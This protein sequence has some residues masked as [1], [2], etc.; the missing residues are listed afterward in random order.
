[1][2]DQRGVRINVY[3]AAATEFAN[4][5]AANAW[6]GHACCEE[7]KR[8]A[9][10]QQT[11]K[12]RELAARLMSSSSNDRSASEGGHRQTQAAVRPPMETRPHFGAVLPELDDV[13]A[14]SRRRDCQSAAPPSPFRRRFNSDGEVDE[15]GASAK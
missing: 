6:A 2:S 5:Y 3:E 1:M 10:R 9:V 7:M 13:P 4:G 12:A 15:E 14:G 11:W 8:E